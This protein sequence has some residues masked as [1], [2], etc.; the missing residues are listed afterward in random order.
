MINRPAQ[1]GKTAK[2]IFASIISKCNDEGYLKLN[3]DKSYM[4]LTIEVISPKIKTVLGSGIIY[5]FCHYYEQN[6]DL[7]QD[8]ECTFLVID[9]RKNED[10]LD[11][12]AVYPVSFKQASIS[13]D[14]EY[15]KI[16]EGTGAIRFNKHWQNDLTI[17]CNQ[18]LKNIKHQQGIEPIKTKR[19]PNIAKIYIKALNLARELGYKDFNDAMRNG[20]DEHKKAL[21]AIYN[22]V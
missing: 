12:F 4:P 18:W 13:K 1:L 21:E 16:D 5:S 11:F 20:K 2:A 7:M 22:K 15:I 19:E 3:N 10:E 17:F 14:D 9:N 8:P 6:G